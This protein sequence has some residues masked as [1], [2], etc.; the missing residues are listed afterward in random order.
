MDEV[1]LGWKAA[2]DTYADHNTRY[3]YAEFCLFVGREEE[4][5]R[6][7]Q[8]LLTAYGTHPYLSPITAERVARA[9]LLLPASGDELRTAVT[10]AERAAAADRTKYAAAYPYFRFVQ[11]LAEYR[12]GRL[13]LAIST[14]R[15]DASKV[16]GPAPASSSPCPAPEGPG[17]RGSETLAAAVAS[18]DWRPELVRDQDDWIYH[19]LRREA[20]ALIL[21]NLPAFLAGRTNPGQ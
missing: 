2:I 13:D 11:G 15:G 3:G 17:G 14:M 8:D 5:R 7:R 12:Q 16:L 20:E 9:C 18:H 1:L 6:A 21:P 19:V 4:Y 10:L